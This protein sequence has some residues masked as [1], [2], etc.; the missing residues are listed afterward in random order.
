MDEAPRTHPKQDAALEFERSRGR[1]FGLAYRLLGSAAEA[2]DAVQDAYLRWDRA[3]REQIETPAAWLTKVVTNLCL[4]RLALARATRERYPGPWL[5]EPVVT[6]GGA[7]GPLE[8]VEQRESV[9]MGVLV[10]LETLSPP[11]RAVFVLREAFGLPY[12][13]IADILDVDEAHARQLHHRA[14]AH[15][16][17]RRKRFEADA[18][19]R[20]RIVERFLAA[21][22]TGDLDG[23]V[24]LLAEDATAWAD[25]GGRTAARRPVQGRER[26]A[27]YLLG[28][29]DRIR[30]GSRWP[31]G[32]PDL[33]PAE[34]AFDLTE[35]NGAPGFIVHAR[36]IVLLVAV[37]E[38][39]GARVSAL[40]MVLNP[41]KLAFATTQ[42]L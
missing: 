2:E 30:D 32:L 39:D 28:L 4:S 19:R 15:V 24:R 21:A 10:L 27:R 20:G 29:M 9:S 8:T 35:V 6:G 31:G 41:A 42:H 34:I 26:F 25:G 38:T 1:L 3:D 16:G 14:R 11:Q 18:A 23:L 36:D 40:H 17:E 22:S 5:P 37:V 12:R 33:D 7:L 13:E